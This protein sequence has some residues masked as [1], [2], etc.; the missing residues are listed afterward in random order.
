[1]GVS[2]DPD[3][4]RVA[5]E[6]AF[7]RAFGGLEASALTAEDLAVADERARSHRCDSAISAPSIA[8]SASRQPFA[9]R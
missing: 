9:G 4:L 2:P 5:C 1:L 6:D 8:E 7:G 3:A